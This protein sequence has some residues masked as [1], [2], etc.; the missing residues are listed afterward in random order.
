MLSLSLSLSLSLVGA[1]KLD[2]SSFRDQRFQQIEYRELPGKDKFH[3]RATV[4]RTIGRQ[5]YRG[6][7]RFFCFQSRE[8]SLR[9]S[10][11]E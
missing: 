2:R 11:R 4:S 5:K 3:Y 6:L 7:S 9:E 8:L 1:Y 10:E